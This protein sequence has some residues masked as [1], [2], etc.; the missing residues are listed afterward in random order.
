MQGTTLRFNLCDARST[1]RAARLATAEDSSERTMY[2]DNH[3]RASEQVTSISRTAQTSGSS[4]LACR[5]QTSPP[6]H[7]GGALA[8]LTFIGWT[9]VAVSL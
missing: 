6:S 7:V 5:L 9:R 8:L 4:E 2:D 1:G 3:R